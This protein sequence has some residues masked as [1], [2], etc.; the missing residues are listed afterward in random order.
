M[1]R[2]NCGACTSILL[3]DDAVSLGRCSNSRKTN[4]AVETSLGLSLARLKYSRRHWH[5]TEMQDIDWFVKRL[6]R[7]RATRL[8]VLVSCDIISKKHC[9]TS[10]LKDAVH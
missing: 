5:Y 2:W 4:A 3:P 8:L 6:S 7:G 9:D 10:D 1:T